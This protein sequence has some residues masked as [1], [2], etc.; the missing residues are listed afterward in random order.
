M[1]VLIE[2][3]SVLPRKGSIHERYKGGKKANLALFRA[4]LK[5]IIK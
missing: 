2:G 1:P 4:V 3:V 5:T